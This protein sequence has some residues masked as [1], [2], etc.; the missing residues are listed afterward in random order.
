MLI[1]SGG[2]DGATERSRMDQTRSVWT[3]KKMRRK[4]TSNE[5]DCLSGLLSGHS[6]GQPIGQLLQSAGQAN[7]NRAATRS[8]PS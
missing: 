6:I 7:S 1:A 5:I 4:K 2:A 8:G 3:P